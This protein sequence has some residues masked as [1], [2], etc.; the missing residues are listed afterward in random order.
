MDTQRIIKIISSSDGQAIADE[1]RAHWAGRGDIIIE[2]R[3]TALH[4]DVSLVICILTPQAFNDSAYH[5]TLRQCR[6]LRLPMLPIVEDI[7]TYDFSA[8]PPELSALSTR[9]ALG[10]RLSDPAISGEDTVFDTIHAWL[11]D[12]LFDHERALFISYCR[13]DGQAAAND[14]Y[15]DLTKLGYRAFLDTETIPGG[16]VV[17]RFIK[18]AISERDFLLLIDS[19][20]AKDSQWIHEEIDIAIQNRIKI[21]VLRLPGGH[22]SLP[23]EIR[24]I[25]E[26]E[27]GYFAKLD[28]FIREA[29]RNTMLFDSKVQD[30]LD[31]LR[32]DV[33]FHVSPHGSR[34]ILLASK[35]AVPASGPVLLEYEH[36]PHSLET[37]YRLHCDYEEYRLLKTPI[38]SAFFVYAGAPLTPRQKKAIA[39]ARHGQPLEVA[40]LDE[41]LSA[42]LQP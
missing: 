30:A 35:S 16:E 33:G 31:F 42:V 14:L 39:W 32:E 3:E 34:K 8:L 28:R 36:A 41:F 13:H 11:G 10:W 21:V 15:D 7:A 18:Q 37:L 25:H 6:Q 23:R 40:T 38:S 12:R 24:V 20:Q 19:P 26:S 17:Q 1:M 22:I 2:G 27:V 5:E 4:D 9:N 29:I